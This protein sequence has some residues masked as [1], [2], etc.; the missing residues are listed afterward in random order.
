MVTIC[1]PINLISANLP[2]LG[3]WTSWDPVHVKGNTAVKLFELP[4]SFSLPLL[5]SPL[6][7]SLSFWDD[8]PWGW[9]A[10]GRGVGCL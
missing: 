2:S 4:F 1:I 5:F 8:G 3:E 7:L 6:S 10:T 9:V